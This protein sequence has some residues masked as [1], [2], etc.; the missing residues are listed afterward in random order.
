MNVNR[1]RKMI[2]VEVTQFNID[3]ETIKQIIARL[4]DMAL[5]YG[6]D[7]VIN[8]EVEPYSDGA[9]YLGVFVDRPE[10]DEVM[11]ARIAQEEMWAERQAASRRAAYE[12]LKR[13]FGE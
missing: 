13:E 8:K 1:E 9:T 10:S 6:E 4:Q 12:A 11:T 7:A 5:S 3:G 2:P